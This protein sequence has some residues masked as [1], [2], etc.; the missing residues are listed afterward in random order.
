MLKNYNP[1]RCYII[2][3]IGGN[4]TTFD[5]ARKL[6]DLAASC[7]VDAIK[8]QT[9]QAET[10]V[11]RTA[12][13]D[14]DNIGRIPQYEFFKQFEIDE[15]LHR[16]VFNYI[17]EKDLD[18][19]ST[20]SHPTDVELLERLHVP[21]YKVGADDVTNLPLLHYV[22]MKKK[23]MFLSTGLC[24]LKEVQE[25]V[26]TILA[27]GNR[28]MFLF[29]TVSNY[30]T[31]AHEVNLKAMQTLQ[32]AFP[33]FPVGFSDHTVGTNA[34]V[35]AAAM[36]ASVLEKHFTYDRQAQGPD[37]LISATA[38]EMK[39]I[40]AAVREFESMQGDGVKA[41]IGKEIGN[42]FKNRKSVV[43]VKPV[44]EGRAI[45]RT[46]IDIKRPGNG[47]APKHIEQVIGCVANRNLKT[48]E[49]LQW[50][51]IH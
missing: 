10:I 4:F 8:L 19:F 32:R 17:K 21:A 42:R 29:H 2:A 30:P 44:S 6:V 13:F 46:D 49:V 25:A 43:M 22:A 48:D 36:G 50:N 45:M 51:D 15:A 24:T 9:Y 14:L 38:E 26:D 39:T 31:R 20:P 35:F 33:Q 40:V 3:E 27:A 11:N 16:R 47:I 41:P 5:Q 34:S 1:N 18:W 23:P 28:Q 37:H 12:L 7:D